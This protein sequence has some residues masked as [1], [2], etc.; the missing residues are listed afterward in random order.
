MSAPWTLPRDI[1]SFKGRR[2]ELEFLTSD[3]ARIYAVDGMTGTGKTAL[4]V[5][6]ATLLS[7]HSP[8]G[9]I[10]VH[11]HGHTP[12]QQPVRPDDAL[13]TLL[14]TFCGIDPPRRP[15]PETAAVL[16]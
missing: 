4:C 11:L 5:R 1:G 3:A 14:L 8:D 12:G 16:R 13:A 2:R 9:Q 15:P 10:Y 6:A 7:D